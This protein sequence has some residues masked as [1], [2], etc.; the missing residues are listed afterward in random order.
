[1]KRTAIIAGVFAALSLVSPA[2]AA[3]N[4]VVNGDFSNPG[5]SGGWTNSEVVPGWTNL[6]EPFVEIGSSPIYGLGCANAACQSMEVNNNGVDAVAQTISGLVAGQ[7][8]NLNWAYGGRPGGGAQALDVSVNGVRLGVDTG[9]YGVWTNNWAEFVATGPMEVLEFASV[10]MGGLPSYGN[11]V[12]NVSITAIPELS[13]WAMM[14]M[15]FLAAGLAG[16]RRK[17][18]VSTRVA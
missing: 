18:A 9:S 6:T 13:T 15:G 14:A 5:V 7:T 10:N 3:V 16:A 11:E 2:F 8:Y 1:M 4:L 12:T 17:S